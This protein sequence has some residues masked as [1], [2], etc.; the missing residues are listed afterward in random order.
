MSDKLKGF[1]PILYQD[2]ERGLIHAM[3]EALKNHAIQNPLSGNII[4]VSTPCYGRSMFGKIWEELK[5]RME[6]DEFVEA[7]FEKPERIIRFKNGSMIQLTVT[8][9]LPMKKEE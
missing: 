1:G 5:L 2:R 6:I 9:D 8:D 3:A 7:V 4:M